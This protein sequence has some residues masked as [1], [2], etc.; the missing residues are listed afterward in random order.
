MAPIIKDSDT[1]TTTRETTRNGSAT[2][3]PG[4]SGTKQQPVALEIPITVNGARTA[5]GSDKREPF[6][7]S[8]KTVMVFGSGAVIK[9]TSSMT[10][11][12]LLFLTNERSKKEVVCQ[13]VKSKNY[14]SASGYVELEFTEPA[15]GF[16]GMRFPGD[17]P[18]ASV[19]N[20]SVPSGGPPVKPMPVAI[21]GEARNVLPVREAKP[22]TPAGPAVATVNATPAPSDS[23]ELKRE[24]TRLQEQLSSMAFAE[25]RKAESGHSSPESRA[26][27]EASAELIDFA[28]AEPVQAA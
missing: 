16:W 25:S 12:Q 3:A 4:D 8:T 6:S 17:R 27:A 13:V 28:K 26:T 23:D 22:A 18:T 15:V 10:P 7:E 11:G 2:A 9:L 5:E 20:G 14:R 1:A 24:A 19:T 21:S